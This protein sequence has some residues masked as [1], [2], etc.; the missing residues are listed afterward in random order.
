MLLKKY[1]YIYKHICQENT[2]SKPPALITA[3][4]ALFSMLK[5]NLWIFFKQKG[6]KV[7]IFNYKSGL[8]SLSE[9]ITAI[10][11]QIKLN[12][13]DTFC[14]PVLAWILIWY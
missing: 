14:T 1:L 2:F 10:I 6:I 9:K 8:L 3:V 5:V 11:I 12:I 7:N 4:F 13:L